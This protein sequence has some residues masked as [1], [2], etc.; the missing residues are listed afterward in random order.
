LVALPDAIENYNGKN[1][2]FMIHSRAKFV[3]D[4]VIIDDLK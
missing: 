1:G 4:G 3:P 2:K